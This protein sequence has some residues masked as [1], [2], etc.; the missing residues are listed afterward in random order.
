MAGRHGPEDE[1]ASS[2]RG[3]TPGEG[4]GSAQGQSSSRTRTR[5]SNPS[6]GGVKEAR[7]AGESTW[8]GQE[9]NRERGRLQEQ[10]SHL[11][12]LPVLFRDRG[13]GRDLLGWSSHSGGE[14]AGGEDPERRS[15][16]RGTNFGHTE[17]ALASSSHRTPRPKSEVAPVRRYVCREPPRGGPH[18]HDKVSPSTTP[19]GRLDVQS[20][21]GRRS[22]PGR[23]RTPRSPSRHG[24]E[25]RGRPVSRQRS[26]GWKRGRSPGERGRG[27]PGEEGKEEEEE[28]EDR[29]YQAGRRSFQEHRSGCRPRSERKIQEEGIQAGPQEVQG[30]GPQQDKL[31]Q[32]RRERR[33]SSRPRHLRGLRKS[34]GHRPEDARS[35]VCS[36]HRGGLGGAFVSRR[37]PLQPPQWSTTAFDAAVSPPNAG[38]TNVPGDEPRE[39]DPGSDHR[40]C[41]AGS[42]VTEPRCGRTEAEEPRDDVA[43]GAFLGGS[44]TGATGER[45]EQPELSPRVQRS[46][47]EGQRGE[48]SEGRSTEAVR[49][50]DTWRA[51]RRRSEGR[52]R[53]EPKRRRKEQEREKRWQEER[54]GQ[55]GWAK[56]TRGVR[57]PQEAEQRQREQ[58]FQGSR[59]EGAVLAPQLSMPGETT[60]PR[61]IHEWPGQSR[62][63][64]LGDEESEKRPRIRDE[65]TPNS[66]VS[67]Q[68]HGA[69]HLDDAADQQLCFSGRRFA[70]LGEPLMQSLQQLVWERHCKVM[71]MVADQIYPLPLRDYDG[72]PPELQSWLRAVLLGLNSLSGCSPL[73]GRAE[74]S[75]LQQK[76]VM[77]LLPFLER[78]CNTEERVPSGGF[79]DLFNVKGVDYRGEEI[80]LAVSFRWPNI[81]GA[82]PKEVATLELAEFCTVTAAGTLSTTSAG[83][84]Y[85]SLS[86]FLVAHPV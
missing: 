72:V 68:D 22:P 57:T 54:Q 44:A 86:S 20:C 47:N 23:R 5:K 4:E 16:P 24:K 13:G 55:A 67:M 80:K 21:R 27:S 65:A 74:P 73:T 18:P 36:G 52:Q 1:K 61:P 63:D 45:T 59:E 25:E 39:P 14:G 82:L 84:W 81:K 69:F 48:Q 75:K 32:Q 38:A 40:H 17:R 51:L 58:G 83:F 71:P 79:R 41:I 31:Q 56:T 60:R 30:Q 2:S 43:R 62:V 46:R 6:G 9:G 37:G 34:E 3:G 29:P 70:D 42:A 10:R 50:Q 49:V 78:M 7:N 11:G 28:A 12:A 33:S 66:K 35:L 64:Y 15:V 8:E 76:V 19:K 53:S 77:G 85:R 26:R